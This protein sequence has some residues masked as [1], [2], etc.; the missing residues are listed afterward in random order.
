MKSDLFGKRWL[1]ITEYCSIIY[2]LY[3]MCVGGISKVI[4]FVDIDHILMS[5]G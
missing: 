1:Q 2:N 4:R 5:K 3:N